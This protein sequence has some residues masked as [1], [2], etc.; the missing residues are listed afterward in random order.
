MNV[1]TGRLGG[2]KLTR[3]EHSFCTASLTRTA[4]VASALRPPQGQLVGMHASSE[5]HGQV[6][7]DRKAEPDRI[8]RCSLGQPDPKEGAEK[9]PPR[10]DRPCADAEEADGLVRTRHLPAVHRGYA[11]SQRARKRIEEAVGWI[12]IIAGTP[13]PACAVASGCAGRSPSPR[14]PIT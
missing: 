6:Q 4:P 10:Q 14:P 8:V 2:G 11:L 9:D 12:K 7:L 5:P 13:E 1:P 3:R